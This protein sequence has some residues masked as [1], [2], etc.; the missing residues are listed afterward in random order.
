MLKKVVYL[1]MS[2]LA[3]SVVFGAE[4]APDIKVINQ[5]TDAVIGA[6][7]LFDSGNRDEAYILLKTVESSGDLRILARLGMCYYGGQGV[8][9][10]D[11]HN[12]FSDNKL[13][14]M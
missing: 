14:Y 9:E 7:R 4:A 11:F 1:S 10:S 3:G 5:N 6:I 2:L 8:N 13:Y 12:S